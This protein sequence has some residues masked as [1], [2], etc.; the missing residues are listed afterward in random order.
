MG[1][2]GDWSGG[3]EK[4]GAVNLFSWNE[5][6]RTLTPRERIHQGTPGIPGSNETYDR[7]GGAVAVGR[8]IQTAGRDTLV[9]GSQNENVGDTPYAGSWTMLDLGTTH[10]VKY[11]QGSPGVPGT[12][13]DRR[14]AGLRLA[15]VPGTGPA[16]TR[17]DNLAVGLPVVGVGSVL[18]GPRWPSAGWTRIT[19]RQPGTYDDFG[20]SLAG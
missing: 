15:V 9:V 2:P 3:R 6:T 13:V 4:A 19:A 11:D 14:G 17:R 18:V 12:P 20:D 7:F 8:G 16:A 10:A 5:K 1:V